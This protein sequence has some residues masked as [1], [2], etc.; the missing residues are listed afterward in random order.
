MSEMSHK[1]ETMEIIVGTMPLRP[2]IQLDD[3]NMLLEE[4]AIPPTV[5]QSAIRRLSIQANNFGLKPVTL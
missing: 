1:G 2:F 5:V 4:F 3:P